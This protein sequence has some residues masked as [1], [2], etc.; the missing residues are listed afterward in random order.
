[1]PGLTLGDVVPDLEL[2]TTHGK[3]RLHDFVGDAYVIIFSHPADFTP[4]CTTELSEMAGYAG[5]FDKRGVKLLGFSCDD[6]ESHKDWIKDIEAYKP[7]RRVGFPIVA[8]PDREAIRQLNMIDADEKDTAGGELPNRALHIVGP[9]KKVKLSFLFPACTGRNMAEVL[10]ATDALLTAARHRVA[11]PVNWKPGERVVI[12]PGVSDEE[13]KARF[14]AGFE[15]AQLP[16]N[17]CYL[18]FTQVD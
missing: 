11:T 7:G 9:D 6:V 17:K 10:R 8:D 15:T 16:S 12:P 14:P 5:E 4:V 3:I 18:R 2:D 13:A 1:M